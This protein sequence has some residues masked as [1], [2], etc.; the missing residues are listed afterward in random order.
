MADSPPLIPSQRR[1]WLV[2]A[3]FSL[4]G[5]MINASTFYAL[6]VVLPDMVRDEG[7]SFGVAGFGF[8]ILGAA[9]G[10][11]SFIPTLL[12]NRHGVRV[13]ILAGT[14][15]MIGGF[16]GLAAAKGLVLYF[17]GAAL[18]G[19][20]YQMMAFIPGTH[21]IAALFVKRA[22]PLG[23]YFTITA[24]GGV[25]G[26]GLALAVMHGSHSNWRLLW[27]FQAM[28]TALV[29]VICAA[30][31]GGRGWLSRAA[32]ATDAAV[33]EEFAIHTPHGV[34]RTA[35]AWT[36]REALA[37]GQFYVLLAAYF[38][39]L[40]V[41]VTV[42]SWSVEHLTERGATMAAAVA[43]LSLE[44]LVQTA[45]RAFGGLVGD[46]VEPRFLLVFA[47]AAVSVG[48]AALSVAHGYP[49]MLVY[50]IGSGIGFGLTALAVTL[51][52]LNYY[53]RT[54]NLELFSLT[55]LIGAVSALGPTL[56]GWL[57]DISGGFASTFQI[58]AIIAGL[59]ALAALVMRPPVRPAD[60]K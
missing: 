4:V 48:S 15:A 7:W 12:I 8:T 57:R 6:G 58:Y 38:A 1:R 30:S 37:T 29:G 36:V 34:W 23:F 28:A 56:G 35:T 5:F 9:V 60:V 40:L 24:L 17:I 47:L 2:L 49:F 32:D 25:A 13:T 22:R 33:A 27:E 10:S 3:A 16:A 46:R 54:R 11:S 59:V 31:L 20:G 53:G 45:I 18:C 26:P 50:A 52:L 44:A 43:M 55:C 41:G 21:V 19:I 42:S 39:H 14:V 51:L